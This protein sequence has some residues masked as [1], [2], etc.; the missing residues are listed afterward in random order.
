MF[1]LLLCLLLKQLTAVLCVLPG[2]VQLVFL[3]I[4]LFDVFQR[5][6]LHVF[7]AVALSSLCHFL[8]PLFYDFL[9][10]SNL[11]VLSH[12]LAVLERDLLLPFHSPFSHVLL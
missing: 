1:E 4:A 6:K 10:H 5:W 12:A 7:A 3:L 8:F 2:S 11:N 9:L